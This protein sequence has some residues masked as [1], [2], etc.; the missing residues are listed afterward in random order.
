M[1]KFM[2]SQSDIEHDAF[3]VFWLSGYVFQST[4]DTISKSIFPLAIHLAR[5]IQI[6]LA[7]AVLASVYSDLTLFKEKIS[8]F[9]DDCHETI[10]I[11]L[12]S[13]FHLVQLWVWERFAALKPEPNL[14]DNGQS[15]L[16]RWNNLI[17]LT[18]YTIVKLALDSAGETFL[19][20]PYV[21]AIS[22]WEFPQFYYDK[23]VTLLGGPGSDEV[24]QTFAT[25]IRVSELVGFDSII[26]QYLPHRVAMQFGMDQDI[27]GSVIR[28]DET[29][30]IAWNYYD[31][32]F[33]NMPLYIPARLFESDV[34]VRYLKWWKSVLVEKESRKSYV[35][36]QKEN[37]ANDNDNNTSN[38][39]K[40]L[41]KTGES[42]KGKMKLS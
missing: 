2:N 5:G 23:E 1:K 14:I 32:A 13:P 12:K 3:L 31:R 19:W 6:A 40:D 37:E 33:R 17:T 36:R 41:K 30:H 26:K 7:P 25:C 39:P 42:S 16:S 9:T 29:P 18:T 21:I 20:R 34:T 10:D 35:P 4:R 8:F 24:L 15:R 28:F 11:T 27:P 22:N 38:L